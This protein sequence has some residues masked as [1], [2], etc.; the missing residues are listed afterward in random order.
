M[1]SMRI[2]APWEKDPKLKDL[3]ANVWDYSCD[4]NN[5]KPEPYYPGDDVVDWW[6]VNI[7]SGNSMPDSTCVT[8]F[9]SNA[10]SKGFPVVIGESTPRGKGAQDSSWKKWYEKYL[11]LMNTSPVKMACYIDW[12]WKDHRSS[13]AIE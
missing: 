8:D 11:K 13:W 4:G 5:L 9:V 2:V 6:G 3:V 10:K 1:I 7:F 12:N